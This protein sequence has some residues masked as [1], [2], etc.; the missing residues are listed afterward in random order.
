[1]PDGKESGKAA[2]DE[3]ETS[4]HETMTAMNTNLLLIYFGQI[5]ETGGMRACFH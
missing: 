5:M 2:D 1:M 4:K 3:L